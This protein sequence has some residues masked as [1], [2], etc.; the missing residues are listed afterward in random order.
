VAKLLRRRGDGDIPIWVTEIGWA[1]G[2]PP[3]PFRAGA[4]GQAVRVGRAFRA[5]AERRR[6]LRVRGIVYFN[7]RDARPYPGGSDFFGLHTGLLRIDGR[8]KPA[9]AAFREAAGAVSHSD[10]P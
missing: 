7:W 4:G 6:E 10:V 5:L 9:L 1:S 2:G 3:S 8:P